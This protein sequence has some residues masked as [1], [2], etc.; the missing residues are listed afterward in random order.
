MPPS[1]AVSRATHGS[2]DTDAAT[3][4]AIVTAPA[5][6]PGAVPGRGHAHF[7]D[8]ES[9]ARA[10]SD[11]KPLDHRKK[12]QRPHPKHMNKRGSLGN[13]VDAVRR[14]SSLLP[15]LRRRSSMLS[16]GLDGVRRGSIGQMF[17]KA[18]LV[19]TIGSLFEKDKSSMM[20]RENMRLAQGSSK[21]A[22]AGAEQ[23]LGL[24]KGA[25][26]LPSYP[27][28]STRKPK[29]ARFRGSGWGSKK[30]VAAGAGTSQEGPLP[31][32]MFSV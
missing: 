16:R 12:R 13:V 26:A 25:A 6:A 3:T 24:G 29:A 32:E 19:G 18:S 27:Q 23:G 14:R 20:A 15:G 1:V 7:N 5:A 2:R 11:H 17:R 4:T 30:A 22:Q 28:S 9:F 8:Q 31:T 21:S 10:V